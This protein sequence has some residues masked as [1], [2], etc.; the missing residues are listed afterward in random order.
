MVTG[1]PEPEPEPPP[2]ETTSQ[3]L[4]PPVF[5]DPWLPLIR[6]CDDYNPACCSNPAP[7]CSRFSLVPSRERCIECLT[8]SGITPPIGA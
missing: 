2:I 8:A 4:A 5:A 3:P 1:E 6:A 7:W